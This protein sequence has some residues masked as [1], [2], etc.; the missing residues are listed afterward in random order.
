MDRYI[1]R[2]MILSVVMII[3]AL[4]LILEKVRPNNAYGFRTKKTLSDPG[5]WYAANRFTGWMLAVSGCV[6][7]AGLVIVGNIPGMSDGAN[8]SL[9][10]LGVF[11]VPLI[12]ALVASTVYVTKL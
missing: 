12:L 11:L 8:Y 7:I 4:P 2:Y 3:V 6:S 10:C 1:I 9:V 5:V